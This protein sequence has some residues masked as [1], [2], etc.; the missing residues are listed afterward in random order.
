MVVHT[1]GQDAVNIEIHTIHAVF[2]V[3]MTTI[4]TT[5]GNI[6]RIP[7]K[8]KRSVIVKNIFL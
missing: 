7:C 5:T 1:V 2:P 8:Y 6:I 3:P 4:H